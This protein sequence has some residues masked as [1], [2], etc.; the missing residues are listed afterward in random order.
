MGRKGCSFKWKVDNGKRHEQHC[1]NCLDNPNNFYYTHECD[2]KSTIKAGRIYCYNC[3]DK[4]VCK[5][6]GM[7]KSWLLPKPSSYG[8]YFFSKSNQFVKYL[9][10]ESNCFDPLSC[11]RLKA[12]ESSLCF[13]QIESASVHV[14]T[15]SSSLRMPV[16]VTAPCSKIMIRMLWRG[17]SS[18]RLLYGQMRSDWK[19]CFLGSYD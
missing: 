19:S 6:C 13:M 16:Q 14:L 4:D 10:N 17:S 15:K 11:T 18:G 1:H 5:K 9:C 2:D 7:N 3:A 8:P 12:L